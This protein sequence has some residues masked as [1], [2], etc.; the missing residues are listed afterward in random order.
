MRKIDQF[1]EVQPE[2]NKTCFIQLRDIILNSDKNL[3]SE[4]K[5]KMPFFNYKNKMFCYL[6]VDKETDFPYI[7]FVE[8]KSMSHPSLEQGNRYRMKVLKINPKKKLDV[9]TVKEVLDE[10]LDLYR[11][12]Q[13]LVKG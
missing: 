7:G 8:G 9:A 5:Y 2:P 10:A 12:G 13:I 11:S 1:Y 3:K 4:W 6:W